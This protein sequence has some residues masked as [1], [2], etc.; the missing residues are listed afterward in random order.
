MDLMLILH[1]EHGG[2]NNSAFACRT[3]TS[4]GTDTYSAIAAAVGALK[5]PLH[6]GAN[7]KV[8]EMMSN[9]KANVKDTSNDDE[10]QAYLAK[11][12]AKEAGDGSGKIYGLG[13]AVYTISD[14]R[15]IAIEK[16]AAPWPRKKALS[17]NWT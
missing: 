5:G 12:L 14:P 17:R 3:V 1:A 4:S 8:R 7:A 10:L 6:G 11:I 9:I 15:T 16:S 13:H 2:G